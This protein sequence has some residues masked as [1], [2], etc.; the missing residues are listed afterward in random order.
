MIAALLLLASGRVRIDLVGLLVLA[1]LGLTGVVGIHQLFS[2][3]GSEAVILIAGMLALGQAL[4]ATGVTDRLGQLMARLMAGGRARA[5]AVLM[6]IAA[7][8]S[9]FVSDVGLVAVF[10]PL[11]LGLCKRLDLEARR[12]LLPLGLAAMLGGML[13]MVGSAGNIV[14][15]EALSQGHAPQLALFAI[16]PLGLV[17][18]AAG[19]LFTAT[20]GRRL[21]PA[22]KA[23]AD[24]LD[25]LRKRRFVAELRLAEDSPLDG[26]RLGEVGAFA[27]HDITI[28]RADRAGRMVRVGAGS[29]LSAGQTLIAAG[30]AEGMTALVDAGV[31]VALAGEEPRPLGA[32]DDEDQV[33]VQ[34]LV[35]PHSP[36]AGR[37][38]R[39]LD[40]RRRTGVSVLAIWREGSVVLQ[41]LAA[42][43]LAPGDLVLLEGTPERIGE[44]CRG[45]GLIVLDE[46]RPRVRRG[47]L[48]AVLA[49][50][51][52][53]LA[54]GAAAAGWVPIQLAVVI[55]VGAAL[56]L[57]LLSPEQAY[58]AVDWH[59]LV[60][61]AGMTPL[62]AALVQTGIAAHMAHVLVAAAQLLGGNPRVL[63]TLL[64]LLAAALTQVLSNVATVMVLAPMA[65]QAAGLTHQPPQLLVAVVIAAVSAAP[66]TP[67]SSKVNL[68]V[69]G[70]AGYR[71]GDFVRFGVPLT[72]LLGAVTVVAAP[73]LIRS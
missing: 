23:R 6:G 70:P 59:I 64:F 57:N 20:V 46:P 45:R 26:Q 3:F 61:I 2:G 73:W 66:I 52:Y 49:V 17:L 50:A 15:N 31:G 40:F 47:S 13:S 58:G 63:M 39:Q 67:M 43:A 42:T 68:L 27:Q 72:L 5:T 14:G 44:A 12:L 41:R 54:L 7:L 29:V 10:L 65:L 51:L 34:A 25:E 9:G 32:G 35:G 16:T 22:G 62:A 4:V 38:V 30:P 19:V 1:A 8:P 11:V 53:V 37:S 55:A 36:L 21:L 69:M 28:L 33:L 60:F 24:M 71:Y 18:L 56:A 48:H